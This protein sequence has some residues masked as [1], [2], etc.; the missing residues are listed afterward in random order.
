MFNLLGGKKF[1]ELDNLLRKAE[2]Y[3]ETI[4]SDGNKV[5]ADKMYAKK[6]F[7]ESHINEN[8]PTVSENEPTVSKKI[9][10]ELLDLA[11][12]KRSKELIED[13]IKKIRGNAALERI[14]LTSKKEEFQ[15]LFNFYEK[16]A[17]LLKEKGKI[18]EPFTNIKS[19]ESPQ[20]AIII[21]INRSR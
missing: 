5:G 7:T 19:K 18:I 6:Q 8:E 17:E 13:G 3:L 21:D 2:R 14:N 4:M 15:E 16:T 1:S 9:E 10:D 20:E 11:P 12:N